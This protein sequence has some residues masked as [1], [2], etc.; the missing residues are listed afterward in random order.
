MVAAL[1]CPSS[2]LADGLNPAHPN[3]H[4]HS[5]EKHENVLKNPSNSLPLFELWMNI[6]GVVLL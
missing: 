2:L 1:Y 6:K 5:Q 3:T 4:T